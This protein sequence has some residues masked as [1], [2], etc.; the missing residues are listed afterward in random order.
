MNAKE[1]EIDYSEIYPPAPAKSCAN[2][3]GWGKY[4]QVFLDVEEKFTKIPKLFICHKC[5][6]SGVQEGEV[7]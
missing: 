2:C 7:K 3:G 1:Y 5:G 6:G 4:R